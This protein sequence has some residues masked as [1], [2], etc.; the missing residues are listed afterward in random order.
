[1]STTERSPGFGP[2][3]LLHG[4]APR[5]ASLGHYILAAA[6]ARILGSGF[7]TVRDVGSSDDEASALRLAVDL[8]IVPGPRILTCGR[9]VSATAPGG[10]IFGSMYREADGPWEM[11]KAVREGDVV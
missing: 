6:G 3:P 4:E 5:P 9:I 7:T 11:R 1:M 10:V 8:G 2:P